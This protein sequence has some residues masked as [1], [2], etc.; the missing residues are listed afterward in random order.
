MQPLN[1][2]TSFLYASNASAMSIPRVVHEFPNPTWLENMA[3]TRN[4][5]LLTGVL[6]ETA[7]LH[8]IDP[9]ASPSSPRN[10]TYGNVGNVDTLLHTFPS[11]NSVFGI[12]E[13]EPDVFAVAT[14]YYSATTGPTLN[15]SSLWS[16]DLSPLSS[17]L[18]PV[19][20]KIVDLKDAKVAN[21]IALFF[22]SMLRRGKREW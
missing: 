19:V 10:G 16:I 22:L 17:A 14:G 13:L 2:L 1:L 6:S 12:S 7:A 20:K 11:A 4:G 8:L 15:S 21:G 18:P 5:S 9:F 3:A